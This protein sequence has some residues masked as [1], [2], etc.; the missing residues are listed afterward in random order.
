MSD[1]KLL[2]LPAGALARLPALRRLK[3]DYNRIGGVGGVGGDGDGAGAPAL[4]AQS[5]PRLEEL[6]LAYNIIRDLPPGA[7]SGMAGLKI[8]NLHG[9]KLTSLR[10]VRR[11]CCFFSSNFVFRL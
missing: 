11:C 2:L 10:Q 5:S 7:L 9:N 3:A 6:S 4:L 1:N 8:L